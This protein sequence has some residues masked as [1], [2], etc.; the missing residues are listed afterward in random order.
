MNL[1]K[2]IDAPRVAFCAHCG[3]ECDTWFDEYDDTRETPNHAPGAWELTFEC[4]NCDGESV[5]VTKVRPTCTRVRK[6]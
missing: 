2:M 4:P 3:Y 6:A 5:W 1:C